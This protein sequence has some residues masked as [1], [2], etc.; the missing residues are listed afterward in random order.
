ME[1]FVTFFNK[2]I[3]TALL[4]S[5]ALVAC[6]SDDEE[7]ELPPF[8]ELTEIEEQFE[9]EV[10]W[11]E[12]IGD[13]V[14]HYF[15]RLSPAIAY[16][17]IFTADRL[18]DAYALDLA[19]GDEL[20]S[21]D[22]SDVNDERSF[23]DDRVSARI[24]GGASTGYDK[25]VWGSENGDVFALNAETG[26]LEWHVKVPGEVISKPEFDSN[27]VIINTASGVLVA[28]DVTTGEEVWKTEQSVPPLSLRGVSGVTINSGGVFVGLAS[29][30]VG[31][32]IIENGQQ[33]WTKEIG[34]PSGSTEL[35]RIVDVDVTPV[36]FG[37][38]VFAISAN[39]NLAAIDLRSGRE[40]WKRK[41]SSYRKLTISG[42]QIFAT[43]IQGHLYAINR[44]SGMELWSNLALT[45]RGTT[46]AVSVGD[47]VVVG[48]FE[49]YL[50]WMS[51]DDGTIVARHHVD[52]SGIYVTPIV[53]E[54]LLYVQSRDGDLEVIKTPEIIKASAE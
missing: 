23:F 9:P 27:L 44:N 50:H 34:E 2:R 48:D 8:A 33:G 26:E 24:A 45:N 4:L 6:S 25:V 51:K 19:T 28:L 47:Y 10:I 29:G 3:L 1:S 49:G 22:L 41:Y 14:E 30:E 36:I 37:D 7:E 32:F 16:G 21:I 31:V 18:G 39:G 54:G 38:K 5:S 42:N 43:D 35:Q 13:G 15:S 20:W 52:S 12:G 53:H 40:V 17:K 11:D 46:G